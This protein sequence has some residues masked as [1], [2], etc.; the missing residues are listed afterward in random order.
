[1]PTKDASEMFR[2]TYEFEMLR[3]SYIHVKCKSFAIVYTVQTI[4][5]LFQCLTVQ[6]LRNQADCLTKMMERK[7]DADQVECETTHQ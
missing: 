5:I 2:M 1:M 3:I 7:L 4:A 6:G